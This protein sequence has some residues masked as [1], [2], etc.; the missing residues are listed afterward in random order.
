MITPSMMHPKIPMACFV[1][2]HGF[3]HA[4]RVSAVMN[5]IYE[6][7]P[8]VVFEIFTET[9]EWF[10]R[11]SL[12]PPFICHRVKTD[13]GLV[14]TSALRFDLRQTLAAL[15][16]LIPF[17]D[18]LLD[19]LAE[20]LTKKDCQLIIADISPL[21]IAAGKRAGIPSV[22][23]ENFTWDWIYD[24]YQTAGGR[25]AE[26]AA[27]LAEI[28]ASADHHIQTDPVCCD[29][30]GVFRAPPIA[31]SPNLPSDEI[32][33]RLGIS[34]GEK[35]VLITM[36]GI[37]ES[38]GFV[39]QLNQFDP[40]IHFV[41][42]GGFDDLLVQ[43]KRLHQV[44]LLP[45]ASAYYHPDLVHAADAVVGKIGYSTLAEV[46]C[47][48]APYGYICR[49]DFRES[50]VLSAYVNENMS[51]MPIT[52]EAFTHGR[53][54][55]QVRELLAMPAKPANGTNGARITARHICGILAREKEMIEVV[56]AD[57]LVIGAAPRKRI[58]GNNQWLHRVVHVLV[59]DSRNRLLLQKRSWNKQVAPG[60]WDT[61]V[62]G[63]VDCGE[64]LMHAAMREMKEE[65][66]IAPESLRFIYQYIHSNE[67]ESELVT[68]YIC[69][70]DGGF[71]HDPEEIDA[72]R[73]WKT[74]HIMAKLGKGVFSDNFEDEFKRYQ[75]W[76]SITNRIL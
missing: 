18:Q 50:A 75:D 36:G 9:P 38:V 44:T 45:H 54:L 35:M 33:R 63:H 42:P 52:A 66:G 19:E 40:G 14:Q 39:H 1:T 64:T 71:T 24:A 48:G 46:W 74:D 8:Y 31:R 25:M 28:F 4:A 43:K 21:G 60:K 2:S 30:T 57:G 7:W 13:V 53:W 51:G 55:S 47:A 22:L 73:F 23:V 56:N 61:S 3:G 10:F 12:Q 49:Q 32:R 11:Q 15:D 5:A 65:L 29:K 20:I 41:A 67:F 37:P 34:D 68:T 70:H 26:H 27:Y 59:F 16:A 69:R 58:H 17:R 6:Q 62:G 72:V 76:R